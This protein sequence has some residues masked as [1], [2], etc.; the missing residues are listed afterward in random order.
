[1]TILIVVT[2]GSIVRNILRLGLLSLIKKEGHHAVIIFPQDKRKTVPQS[3]IDEFQCEQVELEIVPRDTKSFIYRIFNS[4]IK[5]LVSSDSLNVYFDIG[6]ERIQD[7]LLFIKQLKLAFFS[8]LGR[9]RWIKKLARFVERKVFTRHTYQS[10]FETYRPDIVIGTSLSSSLDID[11]MKEAAAQN[12]PTL[13]LLKGWDHT[14]KLLFRFIPDT[15][16][17]L[18][19]PMKDTLISVQDIPAEKIIVGGFPQFDIYKKEEII[20]DRAVFSKKI[21]VDP[22]KKIILFGSEGMWAPQ[23]WMLAKEI[24]DAISHGSL[25]SDCVLVVRPHFTDKPDGN[26]YKLK[27]VPHVI[28]DQKKEYQEFLIDNW[29]PSVDETVHLANLLY[30]SAVLVTVVSTLTLDVVCF[31]KPIIN[32]MYNGLIVNGVDKTS[33]YY[34]VDHYQWVLQTHGV[35]TPMNTQELI[36]SLNLCLQNPDRKSPERQALL[37]SLCFKVDG[38]SNERIYQAIMSTLSRNKLS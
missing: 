36:E 17:T 27:N 5:F 23:N 13:G 9:M 19:Q 3:Y 18:N 6:N 37:E 33:S 38:K 11:I 2:R 25:K 8:L 14:T 24:S 30:H 32:P 29:D 10:L 22:N 16:I 12:I 1:M 4:A 15:I 20:M 21:G 26:L 28:Y 31:N 35:D 34:K 7:E